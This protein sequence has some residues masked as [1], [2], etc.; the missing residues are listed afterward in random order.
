MRP[1]NPPWLLLSAV[2][3]KDMF[4]RGMNLAVAKSEVGQSLDF[5]S[6]MAYGFGNKTSTGFDWRE[7]YRAH[8]AYWPTQA[9]VLGSMVPPEPGTANRQVPTAAAC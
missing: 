5:V 2:Q 3:P 9:V 1:H 7:A 4:A 8:R 6:I